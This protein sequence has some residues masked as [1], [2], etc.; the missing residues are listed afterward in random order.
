MFRFEL[1][2]QV[3]IAGLQV[4]GSRRPSDVDDRQCEFHGGKSVLFFA[5][6]HKLEL[7]SCV[8]SNLRFQRRMD[9]LSFADDR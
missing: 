4:F 9:D 6:D 3:E 7:C 8:E 2:A 1:E 5:V